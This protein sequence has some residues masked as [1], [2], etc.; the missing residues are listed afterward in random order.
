MFLFRCVV[1]KLRV[2]SKGRGPK[3]RRYMFSLINQ[4]TDG[5]RVLKAEVDTAELDLTGYDWLKYFSF[6][7]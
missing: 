6:E 5:D 1:R 2:D 7:K 4:A 3:R